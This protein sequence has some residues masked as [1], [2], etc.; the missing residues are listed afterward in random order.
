MVNIAWLSPLNE[1]LCWG[2]LRIETKERHV[3]DRENTWRENVA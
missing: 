2:K 1:V 3:E